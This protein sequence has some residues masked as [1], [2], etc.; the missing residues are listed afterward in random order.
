V[1]VL[2]LIPRVLFFRYTLT[3]TLWVCGSR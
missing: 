3:S 1:T 2:F